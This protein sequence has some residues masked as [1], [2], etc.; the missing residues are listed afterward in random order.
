MK[1]K[2][3][4]KGKKKSK[5]ILIYLYLIIFI[6]TTILVFKYSISKVKIRSDKE[7][8]FLLNESNHSFKYYYD[9]QSI[10]NTI[11]KT[12]SNISIKNPSSILSSNY[13]SSKDEE[14]SLN[15]KY[16]EDP[17]P[18]QNSN[19]PIVYIYN[20]HQLE[21]YKNTNNKDYNIAPNVML[22]SYYLR[23]S[24]NN[25]NIKSIVETEDV[26]TILKNNNWEYYK[27]Y[28]VTRE[29]INNAIEKNKT[30]KYFI[31]VHR[32]SINYDLTT[33]KVNSKS[34]AKVLFIVG[35]EN[36]NYESNMKIMDTLC[37]KMN[38][39]YKGIC[40]GL[41]KK[42]GPGVNGIYNQ[43]IN[44]NTILIEIGGV[45]NTF[46]EVT[47]TIDIISEVLEEYIGEENGK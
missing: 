5:K 16:I 15:S 40:K 34:F 24:L 41:Y 10:I 29:L 9:K 23:E 47:N 35:L 20:T 3:K 11:L 8:S 18:K 37:V 21:E 42:E 33:L 45:E 2:I 25:K 44:S 22:A 7:V 26:S 6:T 38:T 30:L 36:K 12:I 1:R 19:N 27:S 43:D 28:D 32:D 13:Y 31:D 17:K 39:K 46:E 4:L 14:Y